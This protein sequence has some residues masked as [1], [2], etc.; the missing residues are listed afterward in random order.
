MIV[1]GLSAFE[2]L[3]SEDGGGLVLSGWDEL[4]PP[5]PGSFVVNVGDAAWETHGSLKKRSTLAL[6]EARTPG[7]NQLDCVTG[8]RLLCATLSRL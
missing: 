3:G 4:A 5:T 2:T 6:K 8:P 7:A 1:G